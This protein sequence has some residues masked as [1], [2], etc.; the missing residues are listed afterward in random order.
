M[1]EFRALLSSES[2]MAQRIRAHDW[3]ATPFGGPEGWPQSLR[4]ALSICLNSSFP[5]AIYWGPEL[6][7]LYNDAWSFIPGPRHPEALGQRASDVWS[8]I[9]HVIEPQLQSVL[10]TGRG[11]ATRDQMLPM[12]RHG[13]QEETYWDYSFTPIAGEDGS[14]AGIFNQGQDITSRVLIERRSRVMLNFSDQLRALETPGEVLASGLEVAG[15]GLDVE[16]LFYGD[17]C[18]DT[19]DLRIDACWSGHMLSP[20]AGTIPLALFG[21]SA[22]EAL[23]RGESFAISDI[24]EDTRTRDADALDYLSDM[25]TRSFLLAPVIRNGACVSV[26]A[27]QHNAPR[28]WTTH[29]HNLVRSI[30]GRLWHELS[31][32][33]ASMALKESERRHRLIFEQARD[34]IFTADLDQRISACN[35]A[36]AEAIGLPADQIVGRSI[37]EFIATEEFEKTTAMLQ[38]KLHEG[39]MTRYE[40]TVVT[41]SGK[42]RQW[43]INSAL[44]IDLDGRPIGLHAVARDVTE[45]RAFDEQQRLLINELNHRVKN[46]LALVQGLAQQSFKRDRTAAEG[47]EVFQARLA[48]LAA[49]HDLLTREKWE[50]ATVA[51]LV[52]DATA[53][54][55]DPAGR[56]LASGDHVLLTPKAAISL[57]MALHELGTNA[58]KYGALSTPQGRVTL[59]W[60]LTDD[61]RFNFLW[62]ESNGPAVSPP[63]RQGFGLRM[64]ERALTTDL[65]GKVTLEFA[66]DGIICRI[67]AALPESS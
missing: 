28:E 16:R 27:A 41:A 47:Q 46:T 22:L 49:G 29:D 40:V 52:S 57:G 19:L 43:D 24:L 3:A 48:M 15:S 23:D 67:V 8:D 14:V 5:T 54:Y 56:I 66:P 2:E 33:R 51:D 38:Q 7:L 36:A 59:N 6:R 60:R 65:Q 42:E 32:A 37:S 13:I 17:V 11:F 58:A 20:I 30:A 34:I 64:I 4:S 25:D 12:K 55:A 9:W 39:G 53:H 44:T 26:L 21:D 35:P 50:G 61:G 31:R 62:Q 63:K 45:Q 1:P 10:A 18:G